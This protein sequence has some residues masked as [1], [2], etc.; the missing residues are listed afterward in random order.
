MKRHVDRQRGAILVMTVLFLVILL[1]FAALALDLGR[2]YVLRTEMQNAADAA[3][4][5]AAAELDGREYARGDAVIAAKQLLSHHGRFATQPEL[6]AELKYV[7]TDAP[8]NNAFEFYSWI[9]AELDP[10]KPAICANPLNDAGV[11]DTN[12]CLA[13]GDND[14]H[15]VRV[16]LYPELMVGE[17]E[18]FQISL[19]FLP[20]LGLFVEDGTALTASTRVSAVAGAGSVICNLP[21]VLICDPAEATPTHPS[22]PLVA[23]QMVV[24]KEQGSGTWEPGNFG[25]LQPQSILG[26]LNKDLSLNM[27]NERALDCTPPIVSTLTGGKTSYG[28]YGLNTRF[29]IYDNSLLEYKDQFP[30]APNIIEYPR[31]DNLTQLADLKGDCGFDHDLKYGSASWTETEINE[32]TATYGIEMIDSDSDGWPKSQDPDDGNNTIPG[33]PYTGPAPYYNQAYHVGHNPPTSVRRYDLYKW[34]LGA[35]AEADDE[36]WEWDSGYTTA[37]GYNPQLTTPQGVTLN[38]KDC[39]LDSVDPTKKECRIHEGDPTGQSFNLSSNIGTPGRRIIFVAMLPCDA[40]NITG[41]T[42]GI[43]VLED[44]GKFAKFFLTEH[45]SPPPSVDF[46]AEYLGEASDRERQDLIHTVIQLYE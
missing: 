43:N 18:Y 11:A 42:P 4:L 6:L 24:L 15:Y 46:F 41:N 37:A 28:R 9:D 10:D 20:V 13:E 27:A 32:C 45:A 21:P 17:E 23:G 26:Q 29:G 2:L 35:F 38:E 34:E 30:P 7:P 16:K 44:G 5:A 22:Q 39:D 40:L 33:T 19:Y 36:G 31:D 8:E 14:A 25:F 3:A 1:G 12:K